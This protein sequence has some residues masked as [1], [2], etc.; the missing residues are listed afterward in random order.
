M[1]RT[2]KLIRASDQEA[3]RSEY[4]A[5]LQAMWEDR[6]VLLGDAG[7]SAW[8]QR[9]GQ[10]PPERNPMLDP[11]LTLRGVRGLTPGIVKGRVHRTW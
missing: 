3:A 2:G 6:W 5:G 7:R 10:A 4:T 8:F 1:K 9:H 11:I